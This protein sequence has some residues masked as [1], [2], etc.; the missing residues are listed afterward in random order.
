M[1]KLILLLA[2]TTSLFAQNTPN[3][4]FAN[5]ESNT[6]YGGNVTV[7]K[8]IKDSNGNNYLI[9]RFYAIADFDPSSNETNITAINSQYG[10]MFIA[11]YNANGDFFWVK[12]IGGNGYVNCSAVTIGSN[13]IYI[14]GKYTNTIDFDPTS[15]ISNLTSASGSYEA[16]F[17]AK[18]DLNG[19][20]ITS[21]SI[22]GDTD[23]SINGLNF[24]NNQLFVSGNFSAAVDFD[25]S[26][27]TLNLISNG[28]TD[29]F[30][31]K[32]ST[33]FAPLWAYSIG[34]VG[35]DI[36]NSQTVTSTGELIITGSYLNTVDFNPST[37]TS[38]A[39]INTSSTI[40][41]TYIAKYSTIGAYIWCKDIGAKVVT[42]S[43]TS[44]IPN[45]VCDAT[46]NILIAG[47]FN[48]T[49]DFDPSTAVVNITASTTSTFIAKYD[50]NGNYV[51]VKKLNNC[52]N[53][54]LIFNNSN[55]NLTIFGT[56][57]NT[58]SIDFDPDTPVYNLTSTNGTN[59]FA[60]YNSNGNF[61]Y[62][63]NIKPIIN[64]VINNE[65]D[66]IY[67]TGNFS[68]TND[69]D[70]STG[71]AT[72][73]SV[74]TNGFIAKYS[75]TGVY[76]YAKPIG[77]NKNSN[78]SVNLI[79]TDGVGNIY[80]AGQLSATTDLDPSSSIFNVSSPSG[81][82]IFISKYTPSGSFI[83]GQTIPGSLGTS[84]SISVMNTDTNGNTYIIGRADS[85][86]VFSMYM[87]K[88]DSNG[89]NL[90]TKQLNGS[91]TASRRIVFDNVGNL[92][93]TGRISGTSP[94]DFDPSPFGT[95]NINP[96]ASGLLLS[97][98]AKYNPQGEY[99][100][101]KTIAQTG[102]VG[103]IQIEK[104]LQIKDN[105]LY[106]TGLLGSGTIVFN[107]TTN[108]S[109]DIL[110]LTGFVAKYDLNGNN[111]FAGVF[112][113]N[114][115]NVNVN[116]SSESIT[117]DNEGN[118]YVTT[119]FNGESIDFDLS[120]NSVYYLTS[121]NDGAG[122]YYLGYAISKYSS[123]G[124]FLWAKPINAQNANSGLY[125][126][127]SQIHSF[128]NTNNELIL[129]GVTGG[130]VDFDPSTNNFVIT[131]PLTINGSYIGNIFMAKYNRNTGDFIW[132][133]KIDSNTDSFLNC[134]SMNNNQD[135]FIS[136]GFKETADFDLTTGV[137]TLI[138][139][140]PFWTDRFWAK[141]A[142]SLLGL[143]EN[144]ISNNY[145][146]YPNP[147]T[148]ILNFKSETNISKVLIYNMLGQLVQQ[149]KVN[150]LEGTINIE[151][152]AQG[153]Y[154][155]KVNDIDKGY[156]IIKN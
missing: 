18:Y 128:I 92:Y 152:L 29:I 108:V 79:S 57:G 98:L 113:N 72:Q 36:C 115:P 85:N 129:S 84:L 49:S 66:G 90:W 136:G 106:V 91:I 60:T 41:N 143:E 131:T 149:E 31:A 26:T 32:Y 38:N 111:Q 123:N 86:G 22:D 117:I 140:N 142:T 17:L 30:I 8:S 54:G 82:G 55:T 74:L 78:T 139:T 16:A 65:T 61:V 147:T 44:S 104:D 135:L 77:G 4:I 48:Q 14:A 5:K 153:T 88:Y 56:F 15:N 155:V 154:L 58:N 107:T 156:T 103:V 138:T 9:G 35:K 141:Y 25:P 148:G 102:S 87:L 121:L 120:P 6:G 114:D 42:S 62:A 81:T 119:Y 52:N 124:T 13:F 100:W 3:L 69:F 112:I 99:V 122:T 125:V 43:I 46:N 71:V 93:I 50:S 89:N 11:K 23:L 130:S 83:W 68:G 110:S 75:I 19:T 134:V 47:V 132:A 51:W 116:T 27:S 144:N 96:S 21:I 127:I 28:N 33:L 37:T 10:D 45:L 24:S 80:R 146:V 126:N 2:F 150:A 109:Y 137:Q 1:K 39:L 63:N 12:S 76:G 95:A 34:G 133:N 105:S 97:Y 20:H 73:F 94:I 70:P 145:S 151:K 64:N 67:L 118:F 40:Q 101:A 7:E 59:Y 53:K